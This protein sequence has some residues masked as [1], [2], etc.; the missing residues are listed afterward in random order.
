[1]RTL[2]RI[3]FF[4]ILAVVLFHLTMRFLALALPIL[5]TIGAIVVVVLLLSRLLRSSRPKC[6]ENDEQEAAPVPRW[7]RKLDRIDQ[8]IQA[9][10]T[11]LVN[12]AER[13]RG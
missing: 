6:V 9:L 2:L 4:A 8:R 1:M 5:I 12:R 13:K 7:R 3:L 10:E 11:L